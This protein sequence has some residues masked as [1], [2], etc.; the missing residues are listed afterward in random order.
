MSSKAKET[1][2]RIKKDSNAA[3]ANILLESYFSLLLESSSI[4]ILV[5]V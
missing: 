1:I 2:E 5:L 4:L 3:K